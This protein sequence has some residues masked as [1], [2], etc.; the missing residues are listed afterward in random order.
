MEAI[1]GP[2]QKPLV[3]DLPDGLRKRYPIRPIVC[4]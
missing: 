3:V 1:Y 2:P 4:I